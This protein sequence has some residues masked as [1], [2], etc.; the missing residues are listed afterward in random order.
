MQRANLTHP[1]KTVALPL[2]L[3]YSDTVKIRP[4]DEEKVSDLAA[5]FRSKGQQQPIK[6]RPNTNGSYVVVF[7]EHRLE[8]ARRLGW[9]EVLAAVVEVDELEALELKVTENVQRNHYV[10]PV[11]EGEIFARLL[12]ERYQNNLNAI[13]ESIGKSTSY[14]KDR[15]TVFYQLSPSLKPFVGRQL[16]T[17]NAIAIARVQD[18]ARQVQ[19]AEAVIKTRTDAASTAWGSG[20]GGGTPPMGTVRVKEVHS[21]TCGCGDIHPVRNS[22]PIPVDVDEPGVGVRVVLGLVGRDQGYV[23]IQNPAAEGATLCGFDLR[24]R[25]G[26]ELPEHVDTRTFRTGDGYRLCDNCAKPWRKPAR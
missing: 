1:G 9:K 5:S 24:S 17:G 2:E 16:T 14:I 20:T 10:D 11:K 4:V 25:W 21:C 23:H 7:G 12:K 19:I 15:L 22:R 13:A 3:V 6:V 18:Q 8:A 26:A